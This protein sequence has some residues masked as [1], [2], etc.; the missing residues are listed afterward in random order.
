MKILIYLGAIVAA[1]LTINHFG[2]S[3]TVYVAFIL[4]GLD[5][6]MRDSLHAKWQGKDLWSKMLLLIL[7][8]SLISA[9]FGSGRIAVASF[10]AFLSAGVMDAIVYQMLGKKSHMV[11]ANGSNV[12]SALIDSGVFV[13]VAFGF[14]PQIILLQWL[15]KVLGGYVWSLVTNRKEQAQ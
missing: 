1:N 15:A 14:M 2:P 3:A 4:I 12:V 8:G 10:A 5:M 7:T 11:K 13:T 9:L 6:T